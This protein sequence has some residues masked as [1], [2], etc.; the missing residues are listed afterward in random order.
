MT[1]EIPFHRVELV[2]TEVDAVR[3]A[4]ESGHTAAFGP[5]ADRVAAFLRELHGAPE[6]ILTTSGTDALEMAA[7]LLDLGPGDKVIVPSFTFV[8]SALAFARTGAEIVFADIEPVT[9][10][11]DPAS[12]AALVDDRVR[13]VVAMHYAGIGCQIREL[14]A[15][16]PAGAEIIED[17]AHGLFGSIDGRGLGTFGRASAVSFHQSKN[18][19]AGEGG[20]LVL[21]DPEDVDRA[22]VLSEKGTDRRAFFEGTV[23]KYTWRDTGSSFGLS[24]VLAAILWAQVEASESIQQRRRAV[25][26]RYQRLIGEW[27]A[28]AGVVTPAVPDGAEPGY[29][30]YYLLL[31]DQQTRDRVISDL[32]TQGI[33]TAFHYV[34]LHDAP[35]AGRFASRAYACPVS[36][37]VANRLLRLPFYPSLT[38]AES[39]RVVEALA[40]SLG[41]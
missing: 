12:A 35:A 18:L 30:L 33:G 2:G 17:N 23:D 11:I 25:F 41:V 1:T 24:D 5:F 39:L 8:T 14:A 19:V 40:G 15:V 21:N 13:V 3:A 10:G 38:D 29:H 37:D 4:L 7:L 26:E 34:P 20:A 28:E 6:A 32:R 22:H 36:T 16:V 27:S 9:L 31:P